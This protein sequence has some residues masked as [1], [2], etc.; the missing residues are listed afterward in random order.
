[1]TITKGGSAT[2]IIDSF[3]LTMTQNR[4]LIVG[5]TGLSAGAIA[6][7]M[8]AV[9]GSLS[10]LFE[11]DTERRLFYTG[12]TGGTTPS[13]TIGAEALNITILRTATLKIVLDLDNVIPTNVTTP[14]N[15]DGSPI[16]M[17]Y[18][19]QSKRDAVLANVV[20]A[21]V[22]NQVVSY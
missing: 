21:Q 4:S 14:A 3:E 9:S 22:F 2:G 7:G 15:T 18:E 8:F 17:G 19:F 16:R 13:T 1:V 11:T 12:S 10:I 20:E 5:D 6:P